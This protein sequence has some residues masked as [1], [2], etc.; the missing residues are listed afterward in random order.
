M[1]LRL[2]PLP[3]SISGAIIS[4]LASL[5]RR[6]GRLLGDIF[7]L[8][9]NRLNRFDLISVLVGGI[10]EFLKNVTSVAMLLWVAH[11]IQVKSILRGPPL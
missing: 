8:I 11:D 4:I 10:L 1:I 5:L 7:C 6:Q 3:L 9:I 2:L